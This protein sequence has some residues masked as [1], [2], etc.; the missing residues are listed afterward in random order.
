MIYS[1]SRLLTFDNCMRQGY[2]QYKEHRPSPSGLPATTG[3]IFHLSI[4]YVIKDGFSPD[5]ASYTSIYE[6]NGL[7]EGE[8]ASGIIRLTKQ[9]Y[10]RVLAMESEYTETF[11]EN[12]IIVE[13]APGVEVQGYLDI[14]IDDPAN[15]EL[16]IADFKTSW[17]GYAADKTH[18]LRLYGLLYKIYKNYIPSKFKGK[19]IFPRLSAEFDSEIV[20]TDE[21]LEETRTW[22]LEIIKRIEEAGNDINNHPMTSNKRNCELC[23]FISLCASG[24]SGLLPNSGEPSDHIEAGLIG[25]YILLQE[26][27]IKRMKEGLKQYIK[28]TESVEISKGIWEFKESE[29]SPKID[30]ILLQEYANKNG[31]PFTRLVSVDSKKLKELLDEDTNGELKNLVTYTTPRN[32]FVFTVNEANNDFFEGDDYE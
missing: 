14:I 15:D 9:A 25:E 19:L 28:S 13:I 30:L 17:V 8:T 1:H 4:A 5:I 26:Q 20:F 7:P 11:S 18:Q 32:S 6:H 3:K 2:Y 10:E 12:H 24:Y 29:P 31:I 16:T 27:S 21:M 23:P 22:A